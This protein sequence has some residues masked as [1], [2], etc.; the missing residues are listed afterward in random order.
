[1]LEFITKFIIIFV[2]MFSIHMIYFYFRNRSKKYGELP[3][4]EMMYIR[5]IYGVRLIRE[6][7]KYLERHISLINAFIVTVDMLIF[8]YLG[9][10]ILKFVIMFFVTLLLVYIF[11]R[12]LA[13]YY[14][15]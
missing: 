4:I 1:M 2:L 6:D 14:K 9:S 13:K 7:K 8:F 10:V 11:Y 15:E 3:T 5:N 12:I